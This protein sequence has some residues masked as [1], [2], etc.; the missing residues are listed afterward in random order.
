M[1][2]LRLPHPELAL[3]I[4]LNCWEFGGQEVYRITHQFFFS[5]RSLYVLVWKPRE[6]QEE[7]AIEDWLKRIRLRVS[8]A[9]VII[10][11]T[12]CEE[13]RPELDLPYLK[14][15]FGDMVCDAIDVDSKTGL[16]VSKVRALVAR[17]AAALPQMGVPWNRRWNDA[18]NELLESGVPQIST[19]DYASL[20]RKHK[21]STR[22]QAILIN[23]LHD[24]VYLIHY[25]DHGLKDLIVLHPEWLTK[26]IGYVLEDRITAQA[27]GELDH[28]RLAEIWFAHGN[29]KRDRYDPAL[30][31]YF[32]RLM[33]KF[34]ISYRVPDKDY[35]LVERL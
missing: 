24:L 25:G 26:A 20:C 9:R 18:R 14:Q 6:G 5:E 15:R 11:A 7:N 28:R 27:G 19:D 1:R 3:E 4:T 30:H 23:L 8:D 35:S 21:L 33:E 16:G 31:P 12:H 29:L 17:E 10:V 2:E 13:R 34:D 22:E 32:L